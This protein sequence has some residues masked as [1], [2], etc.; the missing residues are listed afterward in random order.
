MLGAS[1]QNELVVRPLLSLNP[2]VALATIPEG[3][4]SSLQ[5]ALPYQYRAVFDPVS[6]DWPGLSLRYP[7][8]LNTLALYF[9]GTIILV[10]AAGLAIDPC[11]RWRTRGE[12]GRA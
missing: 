5:Q 2:F 7:R 4:A 9:T 10:L 6:Y 8:W 1:T 3:I 11:H 12:R